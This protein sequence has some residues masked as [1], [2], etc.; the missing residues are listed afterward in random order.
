M[1]TLGRVLGETGW[2]LFVAIGL[3]MSGWLALGWTDQ[4][5]AGAALALFV[6]QA[7]ATRA[8]ATCQ[9]LRAVSRDQLPR[10]TDHLPASRSQA[11]RR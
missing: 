1:A 9:A 10:P 4:E 3:A 8:W 11:E 6:C 5:A 7:I 2:R